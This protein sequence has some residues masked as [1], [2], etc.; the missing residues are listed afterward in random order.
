[1]LDS[2]YDLQH[3]SLNLNL[4]A[5]KLVTDFS[6]DCYS[7]DGGITW[8]ALK[9]VLTDAQFTKLLNKDITLA[10]KPEKLVSK[11]ETKGLF[12][13]CPNC[14]KSFKFSIFT[15]KSID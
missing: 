1:M 2:G 13:S 10:P 6:Y 15:I 11:K 3:A 7:L 5:E 9:A 4:T 14:K 8:K 12:L